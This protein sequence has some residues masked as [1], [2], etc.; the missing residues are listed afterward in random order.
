[1]MEILTLKKSEQNRKSH[2][3]L[4]CADDETDLDMNILPCEVTQN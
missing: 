3:H 1:M 2:L 4:A